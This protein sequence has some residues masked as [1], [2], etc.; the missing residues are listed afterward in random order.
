MR[1]LD[2]QLTINV[3]DV[4]LR[5]RSAGVVADA[6]DRIQLLA[7]PEYTVHTR[8]AETIQCC[9][10]IFSSVDKA[11]RSI[12]QA[13]HLTYLPSILVWILPEACTPLLLATLYQRACPSS[14]F[15]SIGLLRP[16]C[17][18]ALRLFLTARKDTEDICDQWRSSCARCLRP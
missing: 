3:L 13:I 2:K 18:F 15:S 11:H 8:T 6:V 12:E 5:Q 9:V 4:S 1:T 14:A 16:L 17:P 10:R 7:Y